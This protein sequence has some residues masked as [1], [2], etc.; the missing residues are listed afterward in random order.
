LVKLEI[1]MSEHRFKGRAGFFIYE[2]YDSRYTDFINF[3]LRL[4][5]RSS[6]IDILNLIN[7]WSDFEP[8]FNRE[9]LER[10]LGACL[11]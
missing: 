9:N 4:N 10:E 6:H 5:D 3:A 7:S 11:N 1:F 2:N 8:P